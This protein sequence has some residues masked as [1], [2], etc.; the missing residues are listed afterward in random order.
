MAVSNL[1]EKELKEIREVAKEQQAPDAKRNG[2]IE[3]LEL[4]GGRGHDVSLSG[5]MVDG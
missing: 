3:K 1:I 4:G 2:I 5:G